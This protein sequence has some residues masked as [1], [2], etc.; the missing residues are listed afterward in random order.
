VPARDERPQESRRPPAVSDLQR[1]IDR[2]RRALDESERARTRLERENEQLKKELDAARRRSGR[3]AAPFAKSL[4]R[5]PKRP[6]RK[7]GAQ[8]GARGRRRI[9]SHVDEQY[10]APLPAACPHC[11]APVRLTGT[12]VQYQEELP[13]ARIVIRAFDVAIGACTGCGRRLQGRHPLQTSDALGAAAVQLGAQLI[14]LV[15]VLN[16]QLGLSFGKIAVLLR[17]LYG[18]TVTPSGLVHAVHR[19]AR[20]ATPTYDALCAQV[21]GSPQVSP[22]E[23]SWHVAGLMHW[24]WAF[25]TARTTVY[26]IH[27]RRGFE[28]AARV[29]GADF[30]GTLVRD[31]WAAYRSFDAAEHQTCLAHLLRRCHELLAEHPRSRFVADVRAI[32]LT[33]L[34][35]RADPTWSAFGRIALCAQLRAVLADRLTR[36]SPVPEIA[37]FHRHLG[38]EAHALWPCLLDPTIDATNW[39]AEQALRP[40]VVTRK[41]CGGNR[42]A[43]GA[44]TQEILASV[45]RTSVQRQINPHEVLAALL[46]ARTPQPSSRLN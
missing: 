28:S 2:L 38:R 20:R 42:S 1:E 30:R 40:A 12:A 7:P 36:P 17:Q 14:A 31:G 15:V 21:R 34:A 6:G 32:L 46:H 44:H 18:L 33:I 25:A 8:Y 5:D 27:A 29:L 41:V 37:R 23:T 3:Q 16:K 26:A 4:T 10:T 43:R 22:D 45:V 35:V 24:L 13:V 19:A 39:R 9:P 11:A